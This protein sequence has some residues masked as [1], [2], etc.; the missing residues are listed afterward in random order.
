MRGV[1]LVALLPSC[2]LPL[3]APGSDEIPLTS[4]PAPLLRQP[5]ATS[6]YVKN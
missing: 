6:L 3:A 2:F 1:R 5:G 4:W